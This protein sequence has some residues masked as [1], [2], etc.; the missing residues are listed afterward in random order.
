MADDKSRL[1]A[2]SASPSDQTLFHEKGKSPKERLFMYLFVGLVVI[3]ILITIIFSMYRGS[4]YDST[5]LLLGISILS[6][7]F[8]QGILVFWIK[9]GLLPTEKLWFLYF[10]GTCLIL[11]SIFTDVL[12][13]HVPNKST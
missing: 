1:V 11:E 8:L 4:V 3:M 13:Y 5:Y 2:G 12:L 6:M 7:G 9:K 10:V